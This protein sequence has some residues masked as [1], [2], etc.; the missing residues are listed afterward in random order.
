MRYAQSVPQQIH[1][2]Q[3]AG[4]RGQQPVDTLDRDIAILNMG[5]VK[6]F[7]GGKAVA[8]ADTVTL[9]GPG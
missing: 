5:E 7:N 3:R 9:A 6:F 4:A 1:A 2:S 8:H